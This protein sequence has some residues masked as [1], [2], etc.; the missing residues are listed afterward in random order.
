METNLLLPFG[1][2]FL[3]H[4]LYTFQLIEANSEKKSLETKRSPPRLW[5]LPQYNVLSHQS[6]ILRTKKSN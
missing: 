2:K 6:F 1:R 3:C 5:L 4:L